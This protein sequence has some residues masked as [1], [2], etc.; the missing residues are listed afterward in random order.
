[1]SDEFNDSNI[2]VDTPI[3][4]DAPVEETS[5]TSEPL[6]VDTDDLS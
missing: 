6:E 2:E 1:M 3:V 4:E 5:D